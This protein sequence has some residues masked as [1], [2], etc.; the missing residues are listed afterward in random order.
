MASILNT[1]APLSSEISMVLQLLALVIIIIGFIVVKRKK[2]VPHGVIMSA[3]TIMNTL[4][5]LTVMIPVALRLADTSIPEFNLLFRTHSLLGLIVETIAIY[6]VAE[7][8]F[9]KPSP[10]CFQRK[11]WMLG[12]SLFWMAELII[13]MLL[14]MKLYP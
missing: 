13:G 8:R 2:F 14:F 5:I 1:P 12:L 11:S 9:Q 6:I 10:T 4:A 7:W 3:A